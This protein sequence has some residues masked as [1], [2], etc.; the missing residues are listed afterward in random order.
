MYHFRYNPSSIGKKFTPDRVEIDAAV[1]KE[2][3][4]I[5]KRYKLSDSYYQAVNTRIVTNTVL[6]ASRCF[7]NSQMK[8]NIFQKFRYASKVLQSETVYSAFEQVD[9]SKLSKVDKFATL[10]RHHNI[11]LLYIIAKLRLFRR[12]VNG[13]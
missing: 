2:L 8:G 6:C 7:F 5:G 11:F 9:R 4:N 1:Y 3:F 12:R 10:F 13:K